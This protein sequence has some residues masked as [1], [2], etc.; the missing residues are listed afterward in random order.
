MRQPSKFH[1]GKF[2]PKHPEKYE[3]NPGLIIYRSSWE[4]KFMNWCDSNPS[5]IKWSS[6]EF[7]IPYRCPTDNRVHRYFPDAKI[8]VVTSDNQVKTYIVE[9]KPD[10]QTRPPVPKQRKTKQFL[11]EVATWGKNE[12]KWKAATTWCKDRGYHFMIITEHHLGITSGGQTRHYP[13]SQI[14]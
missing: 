2:N 7:S 13:Q 10:K 8:Q 9:I 5:V 1:Q 4:L 12:A 3:G 11:Y 6:E 14:N